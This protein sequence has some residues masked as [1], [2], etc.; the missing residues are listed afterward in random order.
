MFIKILG[1]IIVVF[2]STLFALSFLF[3]EKYRM[4]ELEE[5]K[6]ALQM[7]KSNLTYSNMPLFEAMKEISSVMGKNLSKFFCTV[8][9]KLELRNGK[10]AFEIWEDTIHEMCKDFYLT[11]EDLSTFISFG[12]SLGSIDIRLHQESIQSAIDYIDYTVLTLKDK[13]KKDL[14]MC[15]SLGLL[16]GV[17]IVVILL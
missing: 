16:G 3:K 14:K 11:S 5:M 17:L 13:R 12:K 2:S 7:L 10:T 4:D 8:S 9:N 6:Q 15:R 1:S